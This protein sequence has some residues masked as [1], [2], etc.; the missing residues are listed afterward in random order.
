MLHGR[1][2]HL[3]RIITD[4]ECFVLEAAR[5]LHHM[6]HSGCDVYPCFTHVH[7][8]LQKH[9]EAYGEPHWRLFLSIRTCY[10]R[11]AGT[12]A[13]IAGSPDEWQPKHYTTVAPLYADVPSDMDISD[14]LSS[15][16]DLGG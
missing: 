13:A 2:C 7:R 10:D 14:A 1:L 4:K 11:I 9:P 8:F 12:A 6:K 16:M 3:L 15:D 5:C